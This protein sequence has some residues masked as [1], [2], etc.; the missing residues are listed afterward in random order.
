MDLK[1]FWQDRLQRYSVDPL[2]KNPNP[3]ALEVKKYLPNTGRLLDLGA[4]LGQ[5]SVYFSSLG[6]LVTSADL[7]PPSEIVD[8]NNSLP[9]LS[10]SFDI[11]YSHLGLHFFT[12]NRT[13]SL[14]QEIYDALKPN[15][16]FCTT[17][18]SLSDDEIPRSTNISDDYYL[19]PSGLNKRF[20]SVDSLRKIIPLQYKILLLDENG[21]NIKDQNNHFIRLVCQK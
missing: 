19:T 21:Q 12:L 1:S 15:G 18:N 5:D 16:I 10:S 6:Y 13:K 4:G 8:L 20:F 2:S 9:Y 3:F 7:V 17:L 14:F 11:V